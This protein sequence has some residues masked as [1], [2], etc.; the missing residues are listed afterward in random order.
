MTRKDY[1]L[2]AKAIAAGAAE[3]RQRASR[4]AG[5]QPSNS[6]VQM[7]LVNAIADALAEDNSRFDH[8]RFT[9]SCFV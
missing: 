9:A 2:I 8:S 1:E 7:I 5:R 3:V 6:E 4:P